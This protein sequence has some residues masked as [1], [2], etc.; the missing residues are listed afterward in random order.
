MLRMK[1]TQVRSL[2]PNMVLQVQDAEPGISPECGPR[3]KI[4][5]NKSMVPK[6]QRDITEVTEM[7]NPGSI[8]VPH[9]A[10][11]ASSKM[12]SEPGIGPS[13]AKH[14]CSNPSL[15]SIDPERWLNKLST[16]L[17]CGRPGFYL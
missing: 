17:A 3:N 13:T 7:I 1:P 2:I 8:L 5:L 12:I 14:A 11:S 16:C 15:K 4:K 9:M 6:G 10:P